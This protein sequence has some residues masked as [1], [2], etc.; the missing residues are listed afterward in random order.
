MK[1]QKNDE[2]DAQAICEAVTRAP[3]CGL[4]RQRPLSSKSVL[5]LHR[6]RA[7]LITH[8]TRHLK[9]VG[10]VDIMDFMDV[11]ECIAIE[12]SRDR[13]ETLCQAR[14]GETP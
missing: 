8:R 1:T 11:R 7:M 4:P 2:A 10:V 12:V 13:C 14:A 5:A 6:T 3:T 9:Q